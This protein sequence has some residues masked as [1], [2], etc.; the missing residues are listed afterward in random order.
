MGYYTAV[1]GELVASPPLTWAEFKDSP[2]LAPSSGWG[3]R[4]VKLRISEDTT[5]TEEGQ[6]IRRAAV[7]LMPETD[8]ASKFYN[9]LEHV[10]EALD[11]FPGH[12]WSGRLECKGEEAGDLWRVVVRKGRAV[13]I[14]PTITWPDESDA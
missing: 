6:L 7:A 14:E 2:F 5:E 8:A 11:A 12:T 3:E 4:E 13:R 9:L 1:S 10:Q